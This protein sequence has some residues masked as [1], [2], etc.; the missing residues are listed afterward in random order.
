MAPFPPLLYIGP[1]A[2]IGAVGAMLAL[3]GA[4]LLMVVGLVWYPVRRLR[5]WLRGTRGG[6]PPGTGGPPAEDRRSRSGSG[7]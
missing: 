1:G 4:L 7:S 6:E 2:G 5:E 3:L